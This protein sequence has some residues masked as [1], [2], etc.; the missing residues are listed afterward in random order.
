MIYAQIK[1]SKIINTIVLDDSSLLNLFSTDSN[2]IPFDAL[3][4]IDNI[5]PPPS[6]GWVYDGITFFSPSTIA[7]VQNNLVVSII[8]NCNISTIVNTGA[9][10]AIL[11]VTNFNPQPTTGW[12]YNPDGSLSAPPAPG[13]QTYYQAIINAAMT[14]GQSIIVQAAARNISMGI[15]QSGQTIPVMNYCQVL[16]TSLFTGSLYAAITQIEVMIA[17]TSDTKTALAPFITNDILYATMNQIQT[18]LGIPL[19]PNPGP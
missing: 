4:Q 16:I 13:T 11:N 18:Y 2:G 19:T 17:D 5:Y 10:Q 12:I 3:I 15:T 8:P 6:I 7:I 9:Y 1:N 14:F